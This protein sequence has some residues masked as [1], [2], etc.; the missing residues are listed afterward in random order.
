[1]ASET[2][3]RSTPDQ[4]TRPRPH[5]DPAIRLRKHGPIRPML[6]PGMMQSISALLGAILGR[7]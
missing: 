6:E 5:S 7:R 2:I 1:M 3:Y 4:W